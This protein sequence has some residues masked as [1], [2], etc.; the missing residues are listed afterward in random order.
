MPYFFGEISSKIDAKSRMALPSRFKS[1][2]PESHNQRLIIK[3]GFENCLEAYPVN[4]WKQVYERVAK[5]N[6]LKYEVRTFQ[7]FFFR[8]VVEADL[9]SQGRILL[10]Q[11]QLKHANLQKEVL[12]LG[13][14]SRFELWNPELFEQNLE[15][16]GNS[17]IFAR[18][19]EQ[20]LGD[21]DVDFK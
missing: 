6:T 21:I 14:G 13:L 18:M 8:G 5:V 16:D 3:L 15:D 20:I 12:L 7:R 10:P 4:V 2:L 1:R 19:S 17:Q 11:L 9:D